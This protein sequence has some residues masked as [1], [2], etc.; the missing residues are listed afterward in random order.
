MSHYAV[1]VI[2]KD[3]QDIDELLA[4]YDENIQVAP[5]ILYSTYN[6]N[7]KWDWYEKGGRWWGLLWFRRP[8]LRRRRGS[9]SRSRRSRSSSWRCPGGS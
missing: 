4:P 2:H 1:A 7:S 8:V 3:T 6:P 5:Y 9:G